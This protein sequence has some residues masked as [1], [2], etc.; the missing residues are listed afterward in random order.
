MDEICKRI[1]WFIY[2]SGLGDHIPLGSCNFF[3]LQA[4]ASFE[5]CVIFPYDVLGGLSGWGEWC[6]CSWFK[7]LEGTGGNLVGRLR[8]HSKKTYC[9]RKWQRTSYLLGS[10]TDSLPTWMLRW[11]SSHLHRHCT[12]KAS[13]RMQYI[14]CFDVDSCLDVSEML[15]E[16]AT[17]SSIW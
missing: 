6:F 16:K 2:F 12:W 5:A 13:H 1:I 10:A 15:R 8:V 9:T 11:S 4:I 17:D 7:W 14:R 3:G